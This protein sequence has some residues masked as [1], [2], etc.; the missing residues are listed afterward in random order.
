[1]FM[2]SQVKEPINFIS[3]VC[4]KI[5]ETDFKFHDLVVSDYS[6]IILPMS[7]FIIRKSKLSRNCTPVVKTPAED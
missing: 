7:S 3:L 6:Q 5:I 2:E 1:M 4:Q